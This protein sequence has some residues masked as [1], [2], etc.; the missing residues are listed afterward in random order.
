MDSVDIT[1]REVD[2]DTEFDVAAKYNIRSVP[3]MVLLE[4]GVE[5]RRITGSV[6]A[7]K[8]KEFLN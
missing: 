2:I 6:P 5:I 8:I 1:V 7:S 4:D 3:T